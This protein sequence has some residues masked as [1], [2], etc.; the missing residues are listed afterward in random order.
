MPAIDEPETMPI[1][2]SEVLAKF[3]DIPHFE[4]FSVVNY[5]ELDFVATLKC[6]GVTVSEFILKQNVDRT[7]VRFRNAAGDSLIEGKVISKKIRWDGGWFVIQSLME[8][9]RVKYKAFFD[10]DEKEEIQS[11]EEKISS[12]GNDTRGITENVP[13]KRYM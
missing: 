12:L 7:D 10:L 3:R 6:G 5:S 2:L 13:D 4:S 11:S 9:M 8:Q 1:T